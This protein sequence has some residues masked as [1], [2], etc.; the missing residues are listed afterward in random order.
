MPVSEMLALKRRRGTERGPAEASEYPRGRESR[1][2][3]AIVTQRSSFGDLR[4]LKFS[5]LPNNDSEKR[6]LR[7]IGVGVSRPTASPPTIGL[8]RYALQRLRRDGEFAFG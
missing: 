2:M 4:P 5:I 8:S 1:L 3:K 6:D 7:A